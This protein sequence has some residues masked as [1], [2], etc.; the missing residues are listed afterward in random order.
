MIRFGL[1]KNLFFNSI[2]KPVAKATIRRLATN[3][4]LSQSK[5]KNSFCSEKKNLKH[6]KKNSSRFENNYCKL[7]CKCE[8]QT[9]FKNFDEFLDHLKNEHDIKKVNI[10]EIIKEFEGKKREV[11]FY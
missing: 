10:T 8:K 4:A 3:P 9:K 6:K 1:F 5:Q 2:T 11:K 7:Q